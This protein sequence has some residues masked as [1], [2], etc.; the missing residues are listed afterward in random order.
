MKLFGMMPGF[1]AILRDTGEG[2]GGG[3]GDDTGAAP[4]RMDMLEQR[5]G[6]LTQVLT[7]FAQENQQ[8][9][10]HQQAEQERQT[11]VRSAEG[12]VTEA[13]QRLQASRAKLASAHDAGDAQQIA[14]A[15]AEM[16]TAA[17]EHTAARMHAE[18]VKAQAQ[19]AQTQ[20]AQQQQP[21]QR[22][23]DSNLRNWRERNKS[24]YGVDGEMTRAAL[25]VAKEVEGER[26]L[27]VGSP[28][29]FQAIDAR[30]RNRYADRMPRPSG[31]AAQ[32]QTQRGSMANAAPQSQNR[33]PEAIASGYRR[34]GINVDDPEVAKQMQSARQTAVQKGFLPEKPNYGPVVTR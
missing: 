19:R 1:R 23:D 28:Q 7:G 6:K 16:S 14:D 21:Q 9:K 22:V 24:W 27:E 10:Q 11:A 18:S 30:L 17:A 4:D 5:L 34:M 20:P 2:S 12:F 25:E 26:V 15:T 29:Y 3:D 13:Q 8:T 31:G 33:I 32:V